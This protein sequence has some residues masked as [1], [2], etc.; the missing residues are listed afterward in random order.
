MQNMIAEYKASSRRLAGR[1]RQLEEKQTKCCGT[2]E[3][4]SIASRKYML[5]REKS[6][7]LVA[8]RDMEAHPAG[9]RDA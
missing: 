2:M 3:A 8:I 7:L 1:I 6:D 4:E 9:R 5:L